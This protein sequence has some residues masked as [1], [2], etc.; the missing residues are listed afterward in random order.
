M[1]R[2]IPPSASELF[3]GTISDELD[4]IEI[5]V[6]KIGLNTAAQSITLLSELDSAYE[7]INALPDGE[8]KRALTT[9]FDAIFAKLQKEASA[10]I[11]DAGGM[12]KIIEARKQVNPPEAHPWWYFDHFL[13]EKRTALLRRVVITGGVVIIILVVLGVLY[14]RFLAPDPLV[15]ARYSYEEST[16]DKIMVGN[17]ADALVDVEKG[18]A[19][20][21][22][23]PTLLVLKGVILDGLN[24]GTEAQS[25]FSK[26]SESLSKEDFFLL[27]GQAYIMA[28]QTQKA[29]IDSKEAIKNNPDSVQGYLLLGQVNETIG[30]SKTALDNY[31]QAYEIA[32][33]LKQYELAAMAR[34]RM[35]MLMQS[36]NAQ[37]TPPAWMLTPTTTP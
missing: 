27:R 8:T 22:K 5:K 14:N 1:E 20:D 7:K 10:F 3:G 15:A 9:Q 16:R 13:Y 33:K 25:S 28:N 26:A 30:Q 19:I 34:T 11:R 29:M 18:L 21:P 35:A 24:R 23:D 6:G 37:I 17:L 32:D 2:M 12:N 36:M 31:N 4:R